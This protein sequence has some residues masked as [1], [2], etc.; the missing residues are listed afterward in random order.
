MKPQISSIKK[1]NE[2]TP[3]DVYLCED[4]TKV[5]QG[6]TARVGKPSISCA[7]GTSCYHDLCDIGGSISVTPYSLYLE[8]KPNIEPIHVEE[9]CIT[10]QLVNKDVICPLSI[11]GKRC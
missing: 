3:C 10:I 2:E 4:S 5:I 6:N 7:I 9:T 8:I 1:L 11:Y